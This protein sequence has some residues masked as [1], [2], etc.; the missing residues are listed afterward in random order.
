MTCNPTRAGLRGWGLLALIAGIVWAAHSRQE[1]RYSDGVERQFTKG[2]ELFRGEEYAR[3]VEVFDGILRINPPTHRTTAAAIMKGKSLLQLDQNLE[4]SRTLKE[5]LSAFPSSAYIADA[6]YMLGITYGRIRRYDEAI[7]ELLSARRRLPPGDSSRLADNAMGALD[8]LIDGHQTLEDVRRLLARSTDGRE[9]AYLMLKVAEV[10]LRGGNALAAGASADSLDRVFPGHPYA[11]RLSALRGASVRRSSVKLGVLLPLMRAA[12]PSAVKQIG[13]DVYEGIMQAYDEY[14]ADPTRGVGVTLVTVD[15]DRDPAMA[16][17]GVQVLADDPGVIG[18][19]GPVFSPSTLAAAGVAASRNIPMVSPTANANGI[20]AAGPTVF[21]ANPDYE[22]R[23]KGMAQYAVRR[24]GFQTLAVLA[25]AEAHGRV[26]GEAFVAEGIRLGAQIVAAEWYQRGTTDLSQHLSAIRRA[27]IQAAAEPMISFGGRL[28]QAVLAKLVQSGVPRRT[29]DSLIE[30]SASVRATSL[31]GPRARRL[32][33]SLGIPVV[34]ATGRADSLEYAAEGI[35]A[36]YVPI[37]SPEEVGV[38]T[39]QLVYF[40]IAAQIL[41]SGEWNDLKELD[42]NK[43]YCSGVVFESDSHTDPGDSGYLRFAEAFSLRAGKPPGRYALYGY[44]I[45]RLVLE[46]IG[47]GAA[48]RD[49]LT[50][51]LAQASGYQGLHARI[52]LS[53]R[54]V[55]PWLTIL[56]YRGEA[57]TRID[58]LRV[59]GEETGKGP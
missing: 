13:N 52:G 48:T 22:N 6:E 18:I 35:E 19:L 29:L 4:A 25:P 49:G 15:T 59:D 53:G 45:A 1:V 33:D 57:V 9:R 37:N 11:V 24:R 50:R 39:S 20:A 21:Q 32:I 3:A 26:M 2:V 17:R 55:N 16:A 54:R 38:V 41:G 30:R 7:Q 8:L 47:R 56:E 31:L 40:N 42:A 5:F 36:I 28:D 34:S 58:E 23:G 51:A 46:L 12:E 44:D 10:E 14:R 43:R 27:S